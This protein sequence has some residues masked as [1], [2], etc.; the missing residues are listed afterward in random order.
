VAQFLDQRRTADLPGSESL[1]QEAPQARL[2][3]LAGRVAEGDL[4][5]QT[6]RRLNG[7]IVAHADT[8]KLSLTVPRLPEGSAQ[9]LKRAE[10]LEGEIR[11]LAATVAADPKATPDGTYS[12]LLSRS[13]EALAVHGRLEGQYRQLLGIADPGQPPRGVSLTAWTT[14]FLQAAEKKGLSV[15]AALGQLANVSRVPLQAPMAITGRA[16]SLA[17]F[18]AQRVAQT[19]TQDV[20]QALRQ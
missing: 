20:K 1:R 7:A 9:L 11:G 10:K 3:Q 18:A 6:L 13:A 19:L 15:D 12:Q 4:S 17:Y 16:V 2:G 5:A 8:D 14:A